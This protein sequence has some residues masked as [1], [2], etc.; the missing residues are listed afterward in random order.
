V[1]VEI[2]RHLTWFVIVMFSALSLA[3]GALMWLWEA[4]LATVV[5]DLT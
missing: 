2:Y 1:K 5:G 4:R 3:L